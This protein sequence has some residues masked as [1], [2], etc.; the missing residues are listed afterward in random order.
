MERHNPINWENVVH[1]LNYIRTVLMH[2]SG[3]IDYLCNNKLMGHNLDLNERQFDLNFEMLCLTIKE[4]G[5]EELGGTKKG[6]T[7]NVREN[8]FDIVG[9]IEIYDDEGL[10]AYKFSMEEIKKNYR[11]YRNNITNHNLLNL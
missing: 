8:K 4:V 5:S 11:E 3:S 6:G 1:N 10:F 9:S 7:K 2:F